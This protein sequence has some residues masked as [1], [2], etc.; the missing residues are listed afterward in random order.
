[1]NC[2]NCNEVMIIVERC[3]IELDYCPQCKG[4]FFDSDELE[5]LSE[6]IKELDFS[7]PNEANFKNASVSEQ[8]RKCPRCDWEMDKVT[9]GGKPPIIDYCP[10]GHGIFFDFGEL[11]EYVRNNT[12]IRREDIIIQFLQET[13]S[14]SN[15]D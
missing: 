7:T 4:V 5:L 15:E 14:I 3:G 13:L 12:I 1:M 8:P 11:G 9:V 6:A 10:H 2:P